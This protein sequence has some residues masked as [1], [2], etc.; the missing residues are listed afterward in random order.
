VS[1]RDWFQVA[2]PK[3]IALR[4]RQGLSSQTGWVRLRLDQKPNEKPWAESEVRNGILG[5]VV[6]GRAQLLQRIES[7]AMLRALHQW[8][9]FQELVSDATSQV[10]GPRLKLAPP[11]PPAVDD[12]DWDCLLSFGWDHLYN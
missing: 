1:P 8:G 4:L 9:A 12:F 10:E 5:D 7:R 11:P 6:W 2:S 3:T